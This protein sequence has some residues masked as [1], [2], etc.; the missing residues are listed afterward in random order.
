MAAS[1]IRLTAATGLAVWVLLAGCRREG[2]EGSEGLRVR[3]DTSAKQPVSGRLLVFA[4]PAAAAKAA[5]KDGKIEKVDNNPFDPSQVSVAA[6]DVPRLAPGQT[7]A[8]DVETLAFPNAFSKLMPG[9]YAVQA[10]LDVNGDY[11]YGGRGPGDW[12]SDVA[13]VKLGG[14]AIAPLSL[15]RALPGSSE[16]TWDLPADA[17]QEVKDDAAA[18]RAHAEPLDF[19][20]PALTAFW[21]RPVHLRG[22]VLLP[23]GY[24]E[25]T[26]QTYPTVY[27]THG[28]TGKLAHLIAEAGSVD[29]RMRD[30]RMPPMIWVFLDESSASGTHEFAD[31]VNNGPW[32][33][34][35]TA[36][37]IPD[38]EKRYRMD[39]KPSG[40][41][42]TGHS[43]G[44]WA[45]LWLQVRYPQI[46]GG[47]WSTSPD[48][49]DFTDFTGADLYA[50]DANVYRK[51]DGSAMPLVRDKGE[52]K[53]SFEQFAKLERVLGPY[54][55]QMASFE[56]VFSPRGADGRPMPLFDRNTGNVDPQVAAYWRDHYDIAHRLR[57]Q[58]PAL[59][60]DLDGKI[61]VVVGDADTFYLDGAARKLKATLEALGAK[62]DVRFMPGRT[63]FDLYKEGDDRRALSSKIA[64]EMYAVARPGAPK[65]AKEKAPSDEVSVAR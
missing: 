42:L 7:L 38:L 30:G 31:S 64:W 2:T 55:G 13:M 53:A 8:M 23:P 5:A 36:E 12:V 41:F 17:P 16:P 51:P 10:V 61:H 57:T 62:A 6:M 9:E 58:W 63:H 26:A 18:A 28:F 59:K 65:P 4:M 33:T 22:W 54:G 25:N 1:F 11:N 32:G 27:F 40:R 34:A 47:T 49:S 48:P 39:A 37:L 60:A 14:G 50:K 29:K 24:A 52:V 3:L 44:G 45:T 56:W 20:S 46:F 19:Q 43:S 15:A 21:G 35:L